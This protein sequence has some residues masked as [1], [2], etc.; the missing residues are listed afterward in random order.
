M[1]E[2][3]RECQDWNLSSDE[4]L[5]TLL[6]DF[7][8]RIRVRS[9]DARERV[10]SLA[11]EAARV[12]VDLRN[13]FNRFQSISDTQF[14]EKRVNEEEES[15]AAASEE[16]KRSLSQISGLFRGDETHAA[17]SAEDERSTSQM[18]GIDHV[19]SD[20][21]HLYKEAAMVGWQAVEQAAVEAD[22]EYSQ[23][24]SGWPR[25][26][27]KLYMTRA[28]NWGPLPHIIGTNTGGETSNGVSGRFSAKAF[29]KLL[30][31]SELAEGSRDTA[32]DD[33][34]RREYE[35]HGREVAGQLNCLS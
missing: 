19:N 22:T 16:D 10:M 32:S 11:E 1:E 6:K 13:M 24:P 5:L 34:L 26:K 28:R 23:H 30:L 4:K 18:S 15:H 14:I 12:D 17:A 27:R 9:E 7:A 21:F 8:T 29:E 31:V 25:L 33:Q 35:Q 20:I 3:R 2:L